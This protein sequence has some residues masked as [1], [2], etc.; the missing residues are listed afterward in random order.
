MKLNNYI[1]EILSFSKERKT[2]LT[3]IAGR[4]GVAICGI[5]S[6]K[7]STIYLTPSDLGSLSEL[8]SLV[9]FFF[10]TMIAP[11][12][13][14]VIRGFLEWN[15]HGILNIIIKKFITYTISIAFL[16]SLISL[17]L[18]LNW[19]VVK[20]FDFLSLSFLVFAFII[21]QTLNGIGTT[22]LNLFGQRKIY[23]IFTNL[24]AW[25]SLVLSVVIYFLIPSKI[26]WSFG[27]LLGFILG[28]LSLCF[29]WKKFNKHDG[30]NNNNQ[31]NALPFSKKKIIEFSWPFIFTST[32]WWFQTQSYRFV[33]GHEHKIEFVGYFVTAYSLAAM[34]VMISEGIIAQYLEPTFYNRLKYQDQFGQAN[35]WND[36]ARLFLPGIAVVSVFVAF[37]TPFLAKIFL[38][39]AFQAT[40]MKVTAL[41]ALIE[42]MR[43]A[44]T[45]MFHL[46][47][48]KLDN[49]MTIWPAA[50]GA[51]VAPLSVYILCK[52]DPLYG[53]I[54]GLLLAGIL[55]LFTN[56]LLSF[57]VLPVK[58]PFKRIM[59]ALL[60]TIPACMIL[61]LVSLIFKEPTYFVSIIT[62]AS[63][64]IYIAVLLFYLLSSKY[65]K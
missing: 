39:G 49:K 14:F 52:Y 2:L 38:G 19:V 23:T 24:V 11:V 8:N 60:L 1:L 3:I 32:L 33:L 41:A 17:I 58:W 54:A 47:M 35:A 45:M 34:P 21:F 26:S 31:F 50:V 15:D 64:G 57:R 22:G 13:H 62:L 5:I 61:K 43:S 27:Q 44:G 53:T 36:Y 4:V 9:Y 6:V 25:S 56:I 55:V 20:G 40:A 30:L 59:Y 37:S 63:T 46:G 7:I 28:S 18:Q 51:L 16:A 10:I 29:L 12:S 48:A 42:A 65:S